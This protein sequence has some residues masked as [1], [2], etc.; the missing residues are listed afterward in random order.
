M[1]YRLDLGDGFGGT[2]IP[3]TILRSKL[4]MVMIQVGVGDCAVMCG[5]VWG[6]VLGCIHPATMLKSKLEL[7]MRAGYDWYF[8]CA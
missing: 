8:E 2:D 6:V 1:A 3:T 7:V 4:E 5:W